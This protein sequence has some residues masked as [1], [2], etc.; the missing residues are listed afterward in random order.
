MTDAL[1]NGFHAAVLAE[2]PD[3]ISFWHDMFSEFAPHLNLKYYPI[4]SENSIGGVQNVLKFSNFANKNLL[5][6]IDSDYR[7]LFKDNYLNNPYVFHTYTYSIENY[8]CAPKNLNKILSR[9][10]AYPVCNFFDFENFL[11]S[12]SKVIYKIFLYSFEVERIKYRQA[13]KNDYVV[14][15]SLLKRQILNKALCLPLNEIDLKNN[16]KSTIERLRE[17]LDVMEFELSETFPEIDIKH[18][19]QY[20]TKEFQIIDTEAF[21]HFKGHIIYN[22]VVKHLLDKLSRKHKSSFK[23][24]NWKSLLTNN[25]R[26]CLKDKSSCPLLINIENDINTFSKVEH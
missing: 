26:E 6:C 16:G 25:H 23:N 20:L 9:L 7:Y 4:I 21:W 1:K 24:T 5:L 3:D 12:Y 18:T 8:K 2:A 14:K 22:C 11:L 10:F 19:A 17:R 13:I 15:S